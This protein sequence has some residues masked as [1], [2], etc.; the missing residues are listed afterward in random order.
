METR[1]EGGG[2]AFWHDPGCRRTID[3]IV[4]DMCNEADTVPFEAADEVERHVL[5][6]PV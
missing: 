6:R 4:V 1:K 5:M 2:V 3:M